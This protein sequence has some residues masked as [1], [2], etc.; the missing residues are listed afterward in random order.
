MQEAHTDVV[1]ATPVLPKR[2]WL[3][4]RA[5]SGEMV[6]NHIPL[7]DGRSVL[8]RPIEPQDAAAERAFVA[9]MSP[10]TRLRRFHFGLN[11]LPQ[12]MLQAF[13]HADQKTHVALVAEDEAD[14]HRIVAD[15]RYVVD[16]DKQ[17]AEF[18]LAVADAW[19]GLGLGRKL[20]LRLLGRARN[21]GIKRLSGD[22]LADNAPM[23]ALMSR[24]GAN[25]TPSPEDDSL[26]HASFAL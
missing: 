26:I 19:Q 1:L 14:G 24:L 9:G 16:G 18:A 2:A 3:Q 7:A 22:V 17:T 5:W 8:V 20:M 10:S 23:L 6:E 25:C 21:S 13:I 11:E 12:A 15:A 4:A